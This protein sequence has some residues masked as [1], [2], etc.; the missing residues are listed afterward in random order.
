[1]A[2]Q[3]S[4]GLLARLKDRAGNAER[5][6]D[7]N[8]MAANSQPM[9]AMLND[10]PKSD[11]PAVREYLEGMN[12]PFA[13]MIANMV[14]GDGRQAKGFLGA[15]GGLLGGK[16]MF[17]MMGPSIAGPGGV[18]SMGGP[19]QPKPAPKPC[20]EAEVADAEAKL[21]FALPA[22]L[23]QYYLEVANGGV[24]PGGGLYSLK[25]LLKKWREFTHEPIG[26]L[27]QKWPANLLPIQ[28]DEW[29]VVSIERESGELIY[30]DLEEIDYGGWK[31][32]FVPHAD[33]LEAW[34]D[35]WLGQP[36]M[37]EK[38]ERRAERGPPKQLTDEDWRVWGEEDPLH[39][40][41]LRRL[42]IASMTPAERAALGLTEDNWAEKMFDGLDL[43]S[44]KMPTP[45][46]AERKAAKS[47]PE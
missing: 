10:V 27:G 2:D 43:A 8:E 14:A 46:Y 23:R 38:A 26:P 21:G 31:K 42:D 1:M 40:E 15:I 30:W 36:S 19:R 29:D 28:G 16:Q 32:S 33:S 12:T 22:P 13:G 45:G 4:N 18:F 7:D 24:G 44:V 3:L 39:A 41:Y 9:E 34:L 25:E 5:S 37:K 35:K 47:Q 11:D 6:S 20:S 17:G